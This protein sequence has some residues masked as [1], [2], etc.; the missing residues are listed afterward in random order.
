MGD[1]DESLT[2][3]GVI[4]ALGLEPHP[5][6]GWFRRTFTHPAEV[7]DRPIS[8]AIYYLLQAGERSHWHRI[9]ASELWHF[10]AGAPLRLEHS[11]DGRSVDEV[12]LGTDLPAGARPQYAMPAGVWMA[13]EAMGPFSLVGCTVSPGFDFASLELAP[14]GWVPAG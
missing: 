9:D 13:A 6:G 4:D 14:P 2:A 10:Y 7:D 12:I 5:E 11:A 1:G 8:S 3:A